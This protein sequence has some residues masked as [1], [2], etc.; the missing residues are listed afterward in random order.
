MALFKTIFFKLICVTVCLSKIV[1]VSGQSCSGSWAIQRSLTQECVTGQ[2]IG[3]TGGNPVGCPTNPVYTSLQTNTFTFTQPVGTFYIDLRGFDGSTQCP[4][5]EIKIN[6][7]FYP[8]SIG[9]LEDIPQPSSCTGSFA[10]L[11]ITPDGYITIGSFSPFS[12]QGRIIINNVN[13]TSVS[14]STNDANG[15]AF[16]NP[17]NCTTIPLKLES[18]TGKSNDCMALINWKTG[19]EQNIKNIEIQRSEGGSIFNKVG[20]VGPKGSGSF[21]SFVTANVSNSFF[22][23]KFNDLDGYFEYSNIIHINSSCNKEYYSISPNPAAGEIKITGLKNSDKLLI[24]DL[25]GR[26]IMQFDAPANNRLNI[27]SLSPGIY[28][29]QV[30][31]AGD[32]KASLKLIRN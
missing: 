20:E 10:S 11:A 3:Q 5:I 14:I 7:I 15:T 4:R 13:A 32:L 30:F 8:L 29:L 19:T 6:G 18:F 23:L 31:N 2:W 27:Q 28:V 26:I 21:Y 25:L 24:S 16:S 22:R 17:F 1:N 12:S 9:N